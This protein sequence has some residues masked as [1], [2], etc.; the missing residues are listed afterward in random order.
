MAKIGQNNTNP[1]L[2]QTEELAKDLARQLEAKKDHEKVEYVAV[3]YKDGDEL[4]TTQ[5]FSKGSYNSAPL[6][7]AIAAAG[8]KDKVL[9]VV[10]NHTQKNV[11]MQF[12]KSTAQ[13][14]ER[15]PSSRPHDKDNPADWD[16]A[17]K[18]FGDRTDVAYYL[19]DPKD[20][21]RRYDYAD[22]EHW[23]DEVKPATG[24]EAASGSKTFHPAP[25]MDMQPSLKPAQPST[26]PASTPALGDATVSLSDPRATRLQ[27]QAH[28]AVAQM[29]AGLGRQQRTRGRLRRA[30]GVSARL[31]RHRR[32]RAQSRHRR[33]RRRRADL[34]AR[35]LDESGPLRQSRHR[36][37]RRSHR[38]AGR[39]IATPDS[40]AAERKCAPK[41]G[42]AI[43]AGFDVAL[44]PHR[45]RR[46]ARQQKTPLSRGFS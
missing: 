26:T 36:R 4:K 24:R 31:R 45:G 35:A 19:L 6:S 11:D 42:R 2:A 37:D 29:E 34:R 10:H 22:R 12:D 28:E 14:M 23:I 32:G 21:L 13:A 39:G 16:V 33:S 44:N 17:R 7:D 25:E 18:Q 5:L 30:P 43:A 41:P 38:D 27:S 1:D 3:V 20:K 40:G 46:S 9:A 15:L 8:G